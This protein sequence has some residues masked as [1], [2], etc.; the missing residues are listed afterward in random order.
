MK[1]MKEFA[2]LLDSDICAFISQDD[3]AKIPLKINAVGRT[4]KVLQADIA[5][6][7]SMDHDFPYGP[8]HKLIP[9]F[10]LIVCREGSSL[11]QKQLCCFVRSQLLDSSTSSAHYADYKSMLENPLSGDLLKSIDGLAKPVL[12]LSVDGGPDEN[13]RHFKNITQY[14][15]YMHDNDIDYMSVRTHAPNQSAYNLVERSMAPFSKYLA[16]V[17]LPADTHGKHINSSGVVI[18]ADMCRKNFSSA[19]NTKLLLLIVLRF[20]Q[21]ILDKAPAVRARPALQVCRS[22]SLEGRYNTTRKPG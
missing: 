16:G 18:D 13:P 2:L 11:V 5:P 15:K 14:T 19:A 22:A 3:K 20:S 6:I 12:L 7:V 8:S 9:S 17:I 21:S 1:L 4:F 10:Y